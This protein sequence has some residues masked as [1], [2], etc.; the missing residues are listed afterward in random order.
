MMSRKKFFRKARQQ[1]PKDRPPSRRRLYSMWHAYE[2][3]RPPKPEVD[4][5]ELARRRAQRRGDLEKKRKK[6]EAAA[7]KTIR[8]AHR[9]IPMEWTIRELDE[10]FRA[11]SEGL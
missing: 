5:A 7:N 1:A 2:A 11:R 10:T 8:A 4:A 3:S 6:K 9:T